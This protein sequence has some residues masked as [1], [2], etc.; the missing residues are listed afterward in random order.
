M[1]TLT[2]FNWKCSGR[3]VS[4]ISCSGL[5]ICGC[6]CCRKPSRTP[7]NVNF[8]I[9]A[10]VLYSFSLVRSLFSSFSIQFCSCLS[11]LHA[12]QLIFIRQTKNVFVLSRATCEIIFSSQK[13]RER[14]RYIQRERGREKRKENVFFTSITIK[15]IL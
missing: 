10:F 5:T 14:H 15:G 3:N 9:F 11:S 2:F 7:L 13:Q 6:T 1:K 8:F 4:G 12:F